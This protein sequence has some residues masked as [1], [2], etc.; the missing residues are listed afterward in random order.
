MRAPQVEHTHFR[1]HL[2][3][4]DE[5]LCHRT[6]R[7]L[8]AEEQKSEHLV[9]FT[10]SGMNVRLVAG[11]ELVI[12]PACVTL[13]NAGEPYRVGHPY[14]SGEVALNLAMR[15]DVLLDLLSGH[16]P[17]AEGRVERPFLRPRISCPP[18]L[19]LAARAFAAALARPSV[20][21]LAAEEAALALLDRVA[22]GIGGE[23]SP[24]PARRPPGIAQRAEAF[25]VAH[26]HEPL[27]L[28]RIAA[29][30]GCSPYHLCRTFK[31]RVGATVW[32]R[33]QRLRIGAA[34]E[35]LAGGARDLTD[36]ALDL[37]YSSHSH[38]TASFRSEVGTTP[39]RARRLLA[40]ASLAQVRALLR[41]TARS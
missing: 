25:L 7:G 37:G 27:S 33:L 19:H 21:S 34:L 23:R 30:I 12:S 35:R 9:T 31:E 14:G 15:S 17:A 24:R 22:A 3:R 38:F 40:T 32:G 8:S 26:F 13:S 36:L 28:D 10:F 1:S 18:A 11:D 4:V 39:S 2:V 6:D 5:V 41:R 16:D 29:A 20:E